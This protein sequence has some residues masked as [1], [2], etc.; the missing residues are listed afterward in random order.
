MQIGVSIRY[1]STCLYSSQRQTSKTHS[2]QWLK[3]KR[4]TSTARPRST[5]KM[6]HQQEYNKSSL[7]SIIHCF[8]CNCVRLSEITK[9]TMF[10]CSF[11]LTAKHEISLTHRTVC[12]EPKELTKFLTNSCEARLFRTWRVRGHVT[13]KT[14]QNNS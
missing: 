12:F 7:P 1:G 8:V 13:N 6:T 14:N 11:F 2:L 5:N 4:Y 10:Q 3:L 9:G